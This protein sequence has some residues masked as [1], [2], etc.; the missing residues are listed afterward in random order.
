MVPVSLDVTLDISFIFFFLSQAR[1]SLL[2]SS[3][4]AIKP[5]NRVHSIRLSF[6]DDRISKKIAPKYTSNGLTGTQEITCP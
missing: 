4:V 3:N 6:D 2:G 5:H 1:Q